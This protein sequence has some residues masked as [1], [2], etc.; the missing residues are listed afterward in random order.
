MIRVVFVVAADSVLMFVDSCIV[1]QETVH[2]CKNVE[3]KFKKILKRIKHGGQ[4]LKR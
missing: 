1:T 4:T 2:R 3:K